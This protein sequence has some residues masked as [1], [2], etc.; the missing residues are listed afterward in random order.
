M[1]KEY[2]VLEESPTRNG[3]YFLRSNLDMFASISTKGSY[4]LLPARLMN[5][6]YAQYLRYCRDIIGGEITGKGNKYPIVHFDYN[7]KAVNFLT[8]LNTRIYIVYNTLAKGDDT[9]VFN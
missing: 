1:K 9:N 8:T 7:E 2:F 4:N 3:K 5:L 6:S